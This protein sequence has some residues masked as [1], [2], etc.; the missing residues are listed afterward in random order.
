MMQTITA[1]FIY[2]E[3]LVH[4]PIIR[5]MLLIE[6]GIEQGTDPVEIKRWTNRWLKEILSMSTEYGF[7]HDLWQSCLIYGVMMDENPFSLTCERR[8]LGE[9]ESSSRL[10]ALED[11][12]VLKQLLHM[13]FKKIEEV[14]NQQGLSMIRQYKA[15]E[16]S[17]ITYRRHVGEIVEKIRQQCLQAESAHELMHIFVDYYRND[18]VGILGLHRAFSYSEGQLVP[19]HN[20]HQQKLSEL[21]GYE[22]QKDKLLKNTGALVR[23]KPCNNV[24]LYGDSGT[25][26]SSSIKALIHQFY[27]E[28]LRIVEVKKVQLSKLEEIMNTIKVRPFPFIIYM[29][30]L[31]FEEFEVEYKYLKAVI[32]G[33]LSAKPINIAI[34]ATSNRRHFIKET[35]DDRKDMSAYEVHRSDTMQEKL[36]LV[37]RFGLT[38]NYNKPNQ[39]EFFKIVLSLANEYPALKETQESLMNKARQWELR[40]HGLSGRSARQFIDHLLG[41]LD[42]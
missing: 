35:W 38:I 29:D 27:D 40:Y 5:D 13:D 30:D 24:L 1:N 28:G 32:E 25:G 23:F 17:E 19:V 7:D 18:G 6:K 10:L 9:L 41:E 16:K 26:K 34:Y 39:D 2:Y 4:L 37:D 22:M 15:R 14:T 8:G 33:G 12:S 36:S 42:D 11:F 21:V 31:S 20:L 3:N